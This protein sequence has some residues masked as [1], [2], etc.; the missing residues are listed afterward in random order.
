MKKLI[1]VF[2]LLPS[3]FATGQDFFQWDKIQEI[4]IYFERDNWAEILTNMKRAGKKQR[5]SA[6]LVV[7]GQTY[8][9]VGVRFKGNSSFKNVTKTGSNKLPFNIEIDYKD[10]EQ[11]LPGG[12]QKI[13]LSNVFRDPSFV[14]EILAYEIVRKY[15]YAP[16]CNFAKLY[17]NDKYLGLYS[18]T[19]TID[20]DFLKDNF[21]DNDGILVKC[22]PEWGVKVAP[23]CKK[24]DKSSLMYLGDNPA[25][26]ASNYELKSDEGW[27]DFI[28][29]IEVLNEKKEDLPKHLDIDQTLWM[30][31]LNNVLV[32]LDSYTGRLSHNYYMYKGKSGVFTPLIWDL[33]LAF[34][35]FKFDGNGKPLDTKGLQK[36]STMVHFK[37]N[38]AKRPL[39]VN[40][41]KN[42]L[43]RKI[44]IAHIR[45]ILKENFNNNEYKTRAEA[46]QRLIDSEV[47][48]DANKLYSYESFKA[49][50][51]SSADAKGTQIVGLTELMEGRKEYLNNHPLLSTDPPVISNVEDIH[52]DEDVAIQAKLEGATGAI[53]M[54]RKNKKEHFIAYKMKDDGGSNDESMDDGIW[55]CTVP[56]HKKG[57]YYIIAENEKAAATFPA[58]SSREAIKIKE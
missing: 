57:Q 32:N 56:F 31:A 36:L 26:Y 14:R 38:N 49:N 4:K 27:S 28:K 23:S 5:M 47:R 25:C 51:N 29:M 37:N 30:H 10:K 20:K 17:V 39:I 24:G 18:N 41:L 53:A 2:F 16:K 12:Y 42:P 33:N 35:G 21:G 55:G 43:Y 54:Y 50:L 11:A 58:R 15:T 52:F 1:L 45:T 19:Q 9:Q 40:I 13:K 3:L 44:Y 46:F 7:G 48:N 6:K 22:D 34:G 8:E